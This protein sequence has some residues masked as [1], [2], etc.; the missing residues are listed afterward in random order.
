MTT[1]E[2]PRKHRLARSIS[3]LMLGLTLVGF[4]GT[5]LL[6]WLGCGILFDSSRAE[7]ALAYGLAMV[8][9]NALAFVLL[10]TL[11]I[12]YRP[13]NRFGWLA[14]LY[15]VAI[16]WAN[17]VSGYG[18]CAFEGAAALAG[19]NYATWLNSLLEP[20]A[21]M[22]LALTPWLFPDGRFLTARWRRVGLVGI[23]LVVVLTVLQA[24]GPAPL[25]VDPLGR[26]WIDNPLSLPIP[27]LSWLDVFI[28]GPNNL[29]ILMFLGGII[30]FVL[31]WRRSSGEPRQQLKW[32]AFFFATAGTLFL[33]VE[34]LGQAFYPT[35]FEGWFYLFVLLPF[36]LGLP[37]VIGLAIF[38]YRLYDIDVVIRKT[39][40]YAVLTGLLALVYFGSVIV[41]QR[42]FEGATGQQ[43]QLAIV[44]STLTIA[45]LFSPLRTRIQ[46]AIN[47]RFYR[48]KYD[49]QQVLAQFAVT[50]RDETNMNALTAEMAR[51]VQETLEPESVRVWLPKTG[52]P[53]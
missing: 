35:I 3:W 48:K 22:T 2:Q 14:N 19:G 21:F 32:L 50:A 43:S 5:V 45:A 15:G 10:G 47:R 7:P 51:V 42:I 11:I 41:L 26:L 37:V 23:A 17:L 18:Q 40:L 25:R 53:T 28:A 33:A 49:A 31:R 13:D 27:D 12:T 24:I 38:K 29:I 36:W 4:S 46:A 8:P 52:R 34:V 6:Q 39:L 44:L 20:V 30:S 9:L 16:M 1:T